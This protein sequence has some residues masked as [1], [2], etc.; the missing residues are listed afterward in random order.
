MGTW[1][2][3]SVLFG[4]EAPPAAVSYES[5]FFCPEL[6]HLPH[7]VMSDRAPAMTAT[8]SEAGQGHPHDHSPTPAL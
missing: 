8:H 7:P 1:V 3:P 5:T 2:T 4:L 6:P